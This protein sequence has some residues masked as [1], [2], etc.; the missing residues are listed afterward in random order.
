ML[1]TS[2][3]STDAAP[4]S[5]VE[6][7][8][9]FWSNEVVPSDTMAHPVECDPKENPFNVQYIRTGP[10]PT[11]DNQLM[12]DLGVT[13]VAVSGSQTSGNV[14]G[15]L[16]VTYDIE[17]KKPMLFSNVTSRVDS[18]YVY[19]SGSMTSGTPFPTATLTM[20]GL[21]ITLLNNAMTFPKGLIGTFIM[22]YSWTGSTPSSTF[23]VS[24][25]NSVTSVPLAPGDTTAFQ[26]ASSATAL[27]AWHSFQITDPSVSASIV[28]ACSN[29]SG[30]TGLRVFLSQVA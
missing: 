22:T 14:L 23:V 30:F 26:Y 4:A 19:Y 9:E 2:Y 8:N 5:K 12:Y 20:A 3:R 29:F 24:T 11:G 1:Q 21:P 15:D 25:L 7:L 27:M 28:Y 10:V 6:L 13:H 18:A 16:W 17:L